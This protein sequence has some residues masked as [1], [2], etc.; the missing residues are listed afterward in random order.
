MSAVLWL[1]CV[2]I[3]VPCP[4]MLERP[5]FLRVCVTQ[6]F[7][8]GCVTPMSPKW[9]V[10]VQAS[11]WQLGSRQVCQVHKGS[12]TL[13]TICGN[14]CICQFSAVPNIN[15]HGKITSR[16]LNEQVQFHYLF[17]GCDIHYCMWKGTY[18]LPVWYIWRCSHNFNFWLNRGG[19]L[20]AAS[21]SA[22]YQAVAVSF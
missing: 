8:G 13:A 17:I 2:G 5:A 18:Y 15:F 1:R 22:I 16:F 10:S 9:H 6:L 19:V 14:G 12:R 3:P 4:H 20:M 21:S 11:A 7:W